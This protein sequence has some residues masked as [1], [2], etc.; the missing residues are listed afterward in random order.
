MKYLI[1]VLAVL[2]LAP[3]I[4]LAEEEEGL[5]APLLQEKAPK[6]EEAPKPPQ[7]TEE[8]EES[9][10]ETEKIKTLV[11]GLK[12]SGVKKGIAESITGIVAN[13]LDK[14]GAFK[15]IGLDDIQELL[16]IEQQKQ[17]VGCDEASCAAEI[18]GALGAELFVQG[19]VGKLGEI[20]LLDMKVIRIEEAKVEAR[21]SREVKGD[22]SKLIEET[23]V[24]VR[25]LMRDI[26]EQTSGLLMVE[27]SEEGA[28]IK[29]DGTIVASTPLD[30]PLTVAGGMHTVMI[31]KEGF[32]IFRKDVNV[33]RERTAK[34]I[35]RLQP[36]Q[37]YIETY[38]AGVKN[39][40]ILS[41]SITGAGILATGGA[42]ASY[43]ISRNKSNDLSEDIEA[44][45]KKAVRTSS[46]ADGLD[47][48]EKTIAS[49]EIVTIATGVVALAS[50]ITG[51]SLLSTAPDADRYDTKSS[52]Q[53]EEA[54]I[55]KSNNQPQAR[56][57]ISPGA[58]GLTI[59][60][61]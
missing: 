50:L 47:D 10:G 52:I 54:K 49:L 37:E 42:V 35:A 27:A 2:L 56:L 13:E 29:V 26:L 51:I 4:A 7:A 15:V 31:E 55:Q 23:R 17:M 6:K 39:R 28:T 36:S 46:E 53:V 11:T 16:N 38:K 20:Y 5:E 24:A 43:L 9:W 30:E 21:V 60:F 44:Y 3:N 57:V 32:I 34:L 45:N 59:Q 48:R 33:E 40:S 1:L 25:I 12:A 19:S 61:N 58:I 41:W 18:G 14:L 8:N 22:I